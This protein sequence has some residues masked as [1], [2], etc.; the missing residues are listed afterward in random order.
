LAKLF[1]RTPIAVLSADS[2]CDRFFRL[3][4]TRRSELILIYIFSPFALQI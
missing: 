3:S 2:A 4:I 1:D